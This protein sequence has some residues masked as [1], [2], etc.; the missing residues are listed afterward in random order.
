MLDHEAQHCV[1]Y[2]ENKKKYI[3]DLNTKLDD[4]IYKDYHNEEDK[5]VIQKRE[6]QTAIKHGEI[7]SNEKT[8]EDH[9]GEE[10]YTGNPI[11]PYSPF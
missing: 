6:R 3:K 11:N 7:N 1:N 10:F 4:T 9:F 5:N 8:R 2:D